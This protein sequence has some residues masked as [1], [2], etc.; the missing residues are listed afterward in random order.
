[1]TG[2]P[3]AGVEAL[4]H[5]QTP[6]GS[7]LLARVMP[8]DGSRALALGESLRREGVAPDLVAAALT[9]ARLRARARPRL[10]P[11]ADRMWFTPAG[12]EQ[13]TRPEV[14]ARHA[15]RY[16]GAGVSRV[17]DLCCGIG[18]DL[19]ALAGVADHV[20]G[21]DRDPLTAEVA[22]S[23]AEA[24]GV[25][26]RVHV[27]CA[28]A[29]T[30][31]LAGVS[32]VFVDP[33]RRGPRGRALDPQ[34]WS[35]PFAFVLELAGRVPATGAKLAPGIRHELLPRDAEAEWVSVDGDVVECALWCGP[36]T[37]GVR[38]RATVLPSGQAVTG[39]GSRRADAGP[40]GR[41]LVEPDGAVIR[42]GLVAELADAGSGR[43]L[44]PTIAYLTTD[45]VP[46]TALGTAYEIT[47]VL[48]FGVKRLRELLRSRGVGTVTVKK[49]GTAVTPE[50]LRAQLRLRGEGEATLVL[51]RVAGQQTVLV[52]ERLRRPVATAG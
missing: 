36:L 34:A 38:R 18:A 22:R 5:L 51:T 6:A 48:P 41:Y 52:V 29:E 45:V 30:A 28:D 4:R 35:P 3:A 39:D 37:S 8:Y 44:D 17:A 32:G 16:A 15:R 42:A 33:A 12:L 21:V 1:V 13:S 7:A 23:N 2:D 31:D 47:D 11:D 24:L 25:A 43:L 19:V 14:A 9:Q 46:A 27:V 20:L 49:R 40:V 50:Q 26:D 10:G